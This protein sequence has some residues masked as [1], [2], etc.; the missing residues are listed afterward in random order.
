MNLRC[1]ILG[2]TPIG[3]ATIAVLAMNNEVIVAALQ[4]VGQCWLA[5]PRRL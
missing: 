3:Q 5:D 4:A 1:L 2:L